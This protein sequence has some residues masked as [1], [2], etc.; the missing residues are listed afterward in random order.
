[1]IIITGGEPESAFKSAEV[2]NIDGS[3]LCHLPDL[4]SVR[5]HHSMSHG[6]I[7]G[8]YDSAVQQSCVK[9]EQG[10]WVEFPW[11]LQEQRSH[12][13]SW[14]WSNGTT[15]LFGGHFSPTTSEIVSET[16]SVTGFPLKY[17]TRYIMILNNN[18]MN[19]Y[20]FKCLLEYH[21]TYSLK[22]KS[23]Y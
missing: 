10:K 23:L 14:S 2:L 9:F 16:G 4:Q 11:K 1:M 5:R 18:E 19:L 7:C 3:R 15:I 17:H 12:H 21:V 8:G 22:M 20:A 6:M 13:E